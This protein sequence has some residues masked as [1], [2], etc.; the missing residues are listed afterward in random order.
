MNI[1]SEEVLV[2]VTWEQSDDGWRA[3]LVTGTSEGRVTRPLNLGDEFEVE[4]TDERRCI[5]YASHNG[6]SACPSFAQLDAGVQCATCRARDVHRDY[7]EGRS[8]SSRDGDHSVYLAQCADLVK[9]GVT[10]TERVEKRWI[11]QG[12]A[13]A[14]EVESGIT[15]DEALDVESDLSERGLSER[16]RKENKLPI[17][18]A[19][20]LDGVMERFDLDGDVVDLRDR[21]TYARPAR[22]RVEKQG[23][24][25]GELRSVWGQLLEVSGQCI[26]VTPGKCIRPPTQTGLERFS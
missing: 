13:F 3:V 24:C 2:T 8:G 4:I 11:E 9:V 17:P 25:A 1:G 12:A 15:A 14:V 23:R 26:A 18:D 22:R 19:H 5:G 6:A 21:T 7:V 20:R 10:R 16:I